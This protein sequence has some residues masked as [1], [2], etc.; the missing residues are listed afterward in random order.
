[1]AK[2][3]A[4]ALMRCFLRRD[5][6]DVRGIAAA[7]EHACPDAHDPFLSRNLPLLW[8]MLPVLLLGWMVLTWRF[9]AADLCFG[10]FGKSWLK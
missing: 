6:A 3:K 5:I 7:G 8:P 1:M 10:L 2:L 4:A 9:V